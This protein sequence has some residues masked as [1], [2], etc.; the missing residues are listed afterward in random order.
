MKAGMKAACVLGAEILGPSADTDVSGK[1]KARAK[2]ETEAPFSD[3]NPNPNPNP[4]P[5]AKAKAKAKTG[6]GGGLAY[7]Q[8]LRSIL[9]RVLA[10]VLVVTTVTVLSMDA[11]VRGR[12]GGFLG[13]DDVTIQWNHDYNGIDRPGSWNYG[14]ANCA[15]RTNG[16]GNGP[17]I[18]EK[19]NACSAE[20]RNGETYMG[21]YAK[22]TSSLL[23]LL[24][25]VWGCVFTRERWASLAVAW[26]YFP[27][28]AVSSFMFHGTLRDE[29][30]NI[31]RSLC[32]MFV[33]PFATM[34]ILARLKP[35]T[36]SATVGRVVVLV[37]FAG[38]FGA[39]AAS[40]EL[41]DAIQ[42]WT[43]YVLSGA[44]LAY[45]GV[46]RP[47][48]RRWPRLATECLVAG[49]LILVVT[50]V[51]LR[52]VSFCYGPW[53]GHTVVGHL[54]SVPGGILALASYF[55]TFAP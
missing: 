4:K 53:A 12:H 26:T 32:Y 13:N 24:I 1:T 31:D 22:A 47:Y 42:P 17:I 9:L 28:L 8:N 52:Y 30:W 40:I 34:E 48:S 15:P 39:T 41:T 51:I 37:V 25:P 46:T 49:L 10:T 54:L 19:E 6:P 45:V 14:K 50:M 3:P 18:R 44:Y 55:I 20:C 33:L 38:I 43:A 27:T 21:N 16:D 7:F 23:L 36:K 11:F 29:Y 5:K 35:G 2:P